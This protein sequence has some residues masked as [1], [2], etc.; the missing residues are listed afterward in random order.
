M[1]STRVEDFGNFTGSCLW[2]SRSLVNRFPGG[3]DL[4]RHLHI[5][6]TPQ[7]V[8][9]WRNGGALPWQDSR[10]LQSSTVTPLKSLLAGNG[11]AKRETGSGLPVMMLPKSAS[12]GEHRPHSSSRSSSSTD[13]WNLGQLTGWTVAAWCARY[14]SRAGTSL[15][16]SASI[17]NLHSDEEGR[18]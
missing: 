15:I 4:A 6:T 12:L 1:V 18:D 14:S 8:R 13:R 2:A 17:G 5:S 10:S 11:R 16:S 3:S 9:Q 7:P